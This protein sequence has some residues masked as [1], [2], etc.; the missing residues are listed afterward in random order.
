[1]SSHDQLSEMEAY[2]AMYGFTESDKRQMLT[3][4]RQKESKY[5]RLKRQKIDKSMF[6]IIR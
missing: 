2:G 6:D 5:I 1:M 4:L 3:V